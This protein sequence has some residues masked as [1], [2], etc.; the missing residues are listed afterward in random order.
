[1][2]RRSR[3]ARTIA[4]LWL[5]LLL[6][7]GVLA[8]PMPVHADGRWRRFSAAGDLL[9]NDVRALA[10]DHDASGLPRMWVG[11]DE[12]LQ[13]YNGRDWTDH[14]APASGEV[15]NVYNDRVTA[16]H[17]DEAY[18]VVWVGT[19][20]GLNWQTRAGSWQTNTVDHGSGNAHRV[21]RR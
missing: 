2:I 20:H 5:C 11:M 9:S 21:V 10:Y 6:A 12:G 18:G 17:A 1:M 7:T 19:E 13:T 4:S 16:L 3:P 14:T 8:W 15:H